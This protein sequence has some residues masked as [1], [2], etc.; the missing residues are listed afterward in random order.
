MKSSRLLQ[1]YSLQNVLR[2]GGLNFRRMSQMRDYMLLTR[3]VR[4][5]YVAVDERRCSCVV[6]LLR[7]RGR[8]N[9]ADT[10]HVYW[11]ECLMCDAVSHL[12]HQM[13]TFLRSNFRMR[14]IS[15][16]NCNKH[17][18]DDTDCTN[19]LAREATLHPSF[20]V[21]SVAIYPA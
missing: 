21:F 11:A 8:R 20:A 6:N 14:G 7:L 10:T 19:P 4:A 17:Y 2:P 5:Y 9:V 1:M 13:H 16:Q 15:L 18:H 12:S 3:R